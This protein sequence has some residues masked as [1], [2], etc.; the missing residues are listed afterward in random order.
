MVGETT[1]GPA[2]QPIF[3][4]NF[5]EFRTYFGGLDATKYVGTGYQKYELP[6]IA[7]S[8]LS[9][10]NQLYIT[11]VLGISGYDAGL[12]WGITLDAAMDPSTEVAETPV[13]GISPLFTYTA[14]TSPSEVV[15]FVSANDVIQKLY[16]DGNVDLLNNINPIG[17]MSV[18]GE[19][20]ITTPIYGKDVTNNTFTGATFDTTIVSA[21]TYTA[22]TSGVTVEYVSG[23]TSGTT[24]NYS[25]TSYEDVENKIVAVL[26][27]R[28][29][30]DG[31]E[32]LHFELSGNSIAFSSTGNTADTDPLGEFILTGTAET[33]GNFEYVLSFDRRKRSYIINTLGKTEKDNS[34][35][36]Y[37]ESIFTNMFDAY[38]TDEKIRGI[39][40]TLIE[41][42][43]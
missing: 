29:R 36:V 39:N 31:D 14:T 25:G 1:K 42:N 11:R 17:G 15:S 33:I 23:Y 12:A 34:S 26:R 2:F 8:Y 40:T 19:L 28:G 27:S 22:I 9:Q 37:V 24:T 38:I 43:D 6:Y 30:Y 5:D 7:K 35:A 41:Y 20:S 21:S 10:T 32:N 3:I 4:S 18:G 16:D 13:T